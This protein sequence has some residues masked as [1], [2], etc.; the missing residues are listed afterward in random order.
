MTFCYF[1]DRFHRDPYI[2]SF[3]CLENDVVLFSKVLSHMKRE[4]LN[5][6]PTTLSHTEPIKS[7]K[8]LNLTHCSSQSSNQFWFILSCV[9]LIGFSLI[10]AFSGFR[11]FVIF[12]SSKSSNSV[13]SAV[14]SKPPQKHR[15][16]KIHHFLEPPDSL[17]K[18]MQFSQLHPKNNHQPNSSVSPT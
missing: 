7:M 9:F 14:F 8:W 11:L 13:L 1:T 18:P 5:L 17:I 6:E 16:H 2:V 15:W 4:N 3:Y 10:F 12:P